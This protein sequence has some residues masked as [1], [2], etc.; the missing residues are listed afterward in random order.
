MPKSKKKKMDVDLRESSTSMK[1][2]SFNAEENTWENNPVLVRRKLKKGKFFI[3][4][5][6]HLY[7][8]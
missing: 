7:L 8:R 1:I 6:L 4:N 5:V 3:L 2:S